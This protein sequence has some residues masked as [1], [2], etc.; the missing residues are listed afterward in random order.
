MK[1]IIL[2][3][4][5]LCVYLSNISCC[6][7][8]IP[9]DDMIFGGFAVYKTRNDIQGIY[10][11]ADYTGT[12]NNNELWDRYDFGVVLS[13]YKDKNEQWRIEGITIN[14]DAV[15]NRQ[16]ITVGINITE[17]KLAFGYPDLA[18]IRQKKYGNNAY[19]CVYK[20]N[21]NVDRPIDM[22]VR[23]NNDIVTEISVCGEPN[24]RKKKG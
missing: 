1:R 7:A 14:S 17:V 24:D 2:T 11:I 5:C 19:V 18:P 6:E 3:L 9:E 13:Y 16:N 22:F 20:T 4:L 23:W 12:D 8:Y 10:G 21:R 15:M